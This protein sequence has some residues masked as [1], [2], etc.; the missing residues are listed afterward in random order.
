MTLHL[1]KVHLQTFLSIPV[2]QKCQILSCDTLVPHEQYTVCN[3]IAGTTNVR[4][5]CWLSRAC[6][7]AIF[8]PWQGRE[9]MSTIICLCLA[10]RSSFLTDESC[11]FQHKAGRTLWSLDVA[12][13]TDTFNTVTHRI[14]SNVDLYVP[15][16]SYNRQC[17][18]P[19]TEQ[20]LILC[21]KRWLMVVFRKLK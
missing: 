20:H 13:R 3:V 4:G 8:P 14:S 11:M 15:F 16:E 9:G 7:K 21:T 5:T 18:F 12:V 1:L 17:L 19:S 2:T 6:N 10:L